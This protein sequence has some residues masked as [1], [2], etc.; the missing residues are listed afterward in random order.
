MSDD[1]GNNRPICVDLFAGAG[2]LS[3]GLEQ[4]GF[5]PLFAS[6]IMPAYAKTYARNHPRV[7]VCVSDIRK[8]DPAGVRTGLGIQDRTFTVREAA[9]IQSFPDRYVFLGSQAEQYAQVGNAVP[10]MLAQAVGRSLLET[11]KKHH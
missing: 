9:R 11:L 5:Q 10:P 7:Q 2:G 3:E 4:A 8:V 1:H 6:E